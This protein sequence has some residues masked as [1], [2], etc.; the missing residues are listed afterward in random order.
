M[1]EDFHKFKEDI[2]QIE[3]PAIELQRAVHRAVSKAEAE[4]RGKR[5]WRYKKGAAVC[6]IGIA[7]LSSFVLFSQMGEMETKSLSTEMSRANQMPQSALKQKQEA[8]LGNEELQIREVVYEEERLE[9]TYEIPIDSEAN[10]PV[11]EKM[12]LRL[13]AD[14][15]ELDY[16]IHE[17][18]AGEV[19]RGTISVPNAEKLP[20]SFQLEIEVAKLFGKQGEWRFAFPLER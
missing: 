20:S 17:T 4:K 14:G 19:I 8:A 6:S 15:T 12:N 5:T 18:Q 3:I 13:Y 9:I 10:A 7:I 11:I 16:S 1:G 2:E